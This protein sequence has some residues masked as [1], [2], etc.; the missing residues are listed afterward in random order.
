MFNSSSAVHIKARLPQSSPK[1]SWR[2]TT[3]RSQDAPAVVA[4]RLAL[5]AQVLG[6]L[7][8]LVGNVQ[9]VRLLQGPLLVGINVEVALDALL[10]HVGPAVAAHP[11]PFAL[12]ALVLA[13]AAL[14]ALVRREALAFRSSLWTVLDVVSL[15]EAQMAEVVWRRFPDRSRIQSQAELRELL[16]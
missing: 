1:Y 7:F 2:E 12:G 16:C 9:S 10:T 11:L 14:L 6:V 3:R 15:A 5:F 4:E 8:A 13:E